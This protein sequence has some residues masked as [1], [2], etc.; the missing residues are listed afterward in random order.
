MCPKSTYLP[1]LQKKLNPLIAPNTAFKTEDGNHLSLR[2]YHGKGLVINFWATWCAPCV[3]EMPSLNRLAALTKKNNIKVLTISEDR[4]DIS[5]VS[6]YMKKNQL[7]DLP[8]LIDKKGAL[9][10]KFKLD[11]LP[12]T[13]LISTKN[14]EIDISL[15]I[16]EKKMKANH[17]SM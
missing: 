3:R 13:I 17:I 5:F 14:R 2:D 11:G 9:F 15:F 8:V 4:K 16:F 7:Y 10:R 12:S 1:K 6:S